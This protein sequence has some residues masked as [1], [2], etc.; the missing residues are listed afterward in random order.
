MDK[1]LFQQAKDFMENL[2]QDNQQDDQTEMNTEDK[3][4]VS[5]MI[6][7]AYND[8]TP[9]QATELKQFE[10]QLKRKM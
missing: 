4:I 6:Q 8:A 10:E 1:S 9:E 3:T 2:N 7:S 5:D